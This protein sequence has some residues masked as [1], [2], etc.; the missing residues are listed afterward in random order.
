MCAARYAR[1]MSERT[2]VIGR[3]VAAYRSLGELA[4]TI[5]DEWQYINDLVDAYGPSLDDLAAGA[6][7]TA[8]A[9]AAVDEAIAEIGLIKDPHKAIDWLSTFPHIV[10]LA[11]GGDVDSDGEK[12][13]AD[14]ADRG[15]DEPDAPGDEDNPFAALLRRDR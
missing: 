11:V 14:P 10:A 2:D 1:R 4:E 6:P 13:A 5:E 9:A 8:E 12:G 7:L 3:A 15:G